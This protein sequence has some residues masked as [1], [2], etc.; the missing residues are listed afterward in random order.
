MGGFLGDAGRLAIT[1][2]GA[3]TTTAGASLGGDFNTSGVITVSGASTWSVG[4]TVIVGLSNGAGALVIQEQSQVYIGGGLHIGAGDYV[5]LGGGTIRFDGYSR[6][7]SGAFYFD[8]GTIQLGGNRTIGSDAAITD[9]FG[10]SPTIPT[11]KALI[12]EGTAMLTA[13]AP[14]TLSGGTLS[15]DTV[16]MVPGSRLSNTQPAQVP[17]VMIALAGSVI[18]A[19]GANLTV[20][21]ATK[22]NGFYGN[23]TLL[24]GQNTVTLADANDAVFDSAALA[25]LGAG[26]SPGTLEAANGLTLDF[27]GNVTGFG[28]INTPNDVVKPLINNGHI[29]G[30]SVAEAITLPGYVKGVGTFDNVNFTGTFAPGLSPTILSVGN[31]ALSPTSTLIMEL[32]GTSPG[33]GYD[34]ILSSAALAFDGTLQVALINGFSPVAGQSFNLF[35]W[36][37][38]SDTFDSLQLPTLAGLAWDTSQLYTT[39]V[40]SLAAAGL[41]GDYN[42]NGEVDAADYVL[43]RDN[44]GSGTALANDDTPG[45]GQ[46]DYTRWRANFGATAGSGVGAALEFSN[47]SVPEPNSICLLFLAA[48][49]HCSRL[50]PRR[51]P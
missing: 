30:D 45:V 40:L 17:G 50:R 34:Q 44:L 41:L 7:P 49:A 22:V 39:G 37:T 46:D 11:G 26:G 14:V 5:S 47:S 6:S 2:G 15:A 31:V 35:D 20:G 12:V 1:N 32:G 48:A 19:T 33:S 8:A 13:S 24:V 27:G 51:C 29:T 4:G 21:D 42:Q 36:L 43:W 28:S 18:D 16:L 3:V 25:T 10:A 23:G 9:L 38:T